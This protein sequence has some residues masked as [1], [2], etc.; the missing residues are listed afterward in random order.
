MFRYRVNE[1]FRWKLTSK[2]KQIMR[3]LLNH[4][5]WLMNS[6]ID[7]V[8]TIK[9]GHDIAILKMRV[10]DKVDYIEVGKLQVGVVEMH[11]FSR[12]SHMYY[13]LMK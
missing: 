10:Y 4:S 12:G 13:S 11:S 2:T 1:P 8:L 7:T 9:Y 5:I 3:I 6:S